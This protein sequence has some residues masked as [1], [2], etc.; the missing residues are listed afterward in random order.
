MQVT[1]TRYKASLEDKAKEKSLHKESRELL[2]QEVD[3]LVEEEQ[4]LIKKT[5]DSLERDHVELV[6]QAEKRPNKMS[7][8]ITKTNA[9]KRRKGELKEDLKELQSQIAAKRQ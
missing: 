3:N 5:C 6:F 1:H 2:Q 7:S 4:K 9:L 8:L